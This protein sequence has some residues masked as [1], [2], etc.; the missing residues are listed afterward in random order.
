LE[1]GGIIPLP[2]LRLRSGFFWPGSLFFSNRLTKLSLLRILAIGLER[3]F[4]CIFGVWPLT[5][6]ALV[7]DP[8]VGIYLRLE[9]LASILIFVCIGFCNA[10]VERHFISRL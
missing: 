10:P 4:A 9:I 6:P 7:N 2:Y 3:G 1:N 8:C 5:L